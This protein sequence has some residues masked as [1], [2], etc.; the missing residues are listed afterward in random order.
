[1]AKKARKKTVIRKNTESKIQF[2]LMKFLRA[3]GWIVENIHGNIFQSG[4]PDLYCYN[5]QYGERW[6]D[7]KVEGRYS[8]TKAQIIKWP[9]WEKA[10]IGIW[11]LTGPT[12]KD[13]DRLFEPPNFRDYWKKSYGKL[14][15]IDKLI[16]ELN[17]STD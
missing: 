2:R 10:G 1:M 5:R 13:Y 6:V 14:T 9:L 16:R 17:E 7:V 12:Q 4:L 11:I 15:D 8:F 3:R